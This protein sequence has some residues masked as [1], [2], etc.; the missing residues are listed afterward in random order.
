MLPED[1]LYI[2]TIAEDAETLA[3]RFPVGLELDAFCTAENMDAPGFAQWDATVR[4]QLA[5]AR[6]G[7]HLLHAPFAELFPAAVD[8]LARALAAQRFGQALQIAQGYG[9]DRMVVHAGFVPL[10]YD[11]DWFVE[12]SAIF[13]QAFLED[14]PDGIT[15]LL[16]NVLEEDPAMLAALIDRIGDPRVRL[17]L[18]VGHAHWRSDVPLRAWIDTL[19]ARVGHVHLHNNHGDRDAH[20]GW[21]EGSIPM[22]DVVQQLRQRAPEATFT[23]EMRQVGSSLDALA[24]CWEDASDA[25]DTI[26][27]GAQPDAA[28][29]L[30][31]QVFG[32]DAFREGQRAL[33]DAQ[34]AGHDAVGVMPTG[35]GKSIAFQLPALLMDG[36]T[37]VISPL[38]SLMKDQVGALRQAGVAAAY[39]NS[40]LTEG[41]FDRALR[42]AEAG[43]YRLIYVAPE[44]PL[45]PRFLRFAQNTNIAL[46]AVDEA[47]CISQWGQDFR[48]SYLD[49]PQFLAQLP[50]R[51]VVSAF[52]ATATPQ[53]REDIERLLALQR[54]TVVQTGFDRPNLFYE[55]QR[56]SKKQDAL[57]A[58]LP[59][60]EGQGGIIYCATRKAVEEL[61]TLL[62]A[63]GIAATRYHAGLSDAERQRNQDDFTYDRCPVIVATNA[64]GMG[65]DKSNV[66]FVIHYNMP[67]DIESYYQEAGRAGRDGERAEC[68]LLYSAQDRQTQR[69]LIER[70]DESSDI[71]PALRRQVRDKALTRLGQME[72][73]CRS[74]GCLRQ[75]ILEYFG[76]KAPNACGHCG[77]CTSQTPATDVT[78]V[79]L[80][81]LQC[82]RDTGQRYGLG[83]IVKLL[84]GSNA[85]RERL[86]QFGTEAPDD[87]GRLGSVSRELLQ[88]IGDQLIGEGYLTIREGRLPI[89]ALGPRGID[90]LRDGGKIAL[91]LPEQVRRGKIRAG[92][93]PLSAEDLEL[94]GAL[95]AVRSE[96]AAKYAVPPYFIFSDATLRDLCVK[97]PQ[98]KNDML[99][100]KGVGQSKLLRYGDIFLK[101]LRAYPPEGNA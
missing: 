93:E 76:E 53:V 6:P 97:R 75:Q 69:F 12:Q 23:L 33:I 20:L 52:T 67:R 2:A 31:K 38:I 72:Q 65:I 71:D 45:T 88:S 34:L 73:Y 27:I 47:H 15:L 30:L 36:V 50:R 48:P 17:C 5:A 37:L 7:P 81:I 101:T 98:T 4:R 90:A 83:T 35:S 61:C 80:V 18:D 22:R 62:C 16:E 28:A 89:A 1:R 8:P 77:N 74:Q 58:L 57:L 63:Q 99:D 39:L 78:D 92:D 84:R 46:L 82:V 24:A 14:K 79:A 66:R 26:T 49:I 43:Q 19:G 86:R 21:N 59:R 25:D 96:L 54:P 9:I 55:V 29:D 60:Y 94:L 64:F 91:R 10:L 40:S 85:E 13:W 41:Q 56:P 100:V 44:R 87:F 95:R 11:P 3:A 70:D 68:V 32:Y 42:N 51:P